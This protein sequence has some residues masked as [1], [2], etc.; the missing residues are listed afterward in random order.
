MDRIED[1]TV[2]Y[3]FFLQRSEA[4][5]RRRADVPHPELWA[6]EPRTK[7]AASRRPSAVAASSSGSRS[8]A[9]RAK[10]GAGF[11]AQH[12]AQE[13]KGTGGAAV[14][15]RRSVR[16]R[17]NRC[18]RKKKAGRNDPCPCGSGKKYKKCCGAS[19]EPRTTPWLCAPDLEPRTTPWLC[20][21]D[22]DRARRLGCALRTKG[23]RS[24]AAHSG[25]TDFS[26]CSGVTLLMALVICTGAAHAAI[27]PDQ[28]GDFKKGP[29]EDRH[30]SRSGALR[31]IR[32]RRDRAGGLHLRRQAFFGHRLAL[33]RFHRRH[34][35]VRIR[36]PPGAIPATPGCWLP[37]PRRNPSW[38]Q[39]GRAH[40]RRS[41]LRLRKL[42]VP[43]HRHRAPGRSSAGL[44]GLPKLENRRCRR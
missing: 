26:L 4:I 30:R 25:G 43:V 13:G 33:A 15:G 14:R 3:L 16:P 28:I 44:Q 35:A 18:S 22:L 20:A 5:R 24:D 8:A 32:S 21:P 12:P 34:G 10:F 41:H 27:F 7:T 11:D 19:F 2:R 23:D 36:R 9:G 40:F 31:R 1:E 39:A 42:R 38:L 29:V 37:S 6:D 17:S